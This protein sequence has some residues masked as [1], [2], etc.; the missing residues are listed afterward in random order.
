M[1]S[2]HH[3]QNENGFAKPFRTFRHR[4]KFKH[5]PWL[6]F[7]MAAFNSEDSWNQIFDPLRATTRGRC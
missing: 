3:R 4:R 6:V 7:N 5:D 1:N 2:T